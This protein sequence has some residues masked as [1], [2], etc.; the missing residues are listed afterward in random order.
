MKQESLEVDASQVDAIADVIS[1]YW[2]I[3]LINFIQKKYYEL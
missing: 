3:S 1:R 2:K